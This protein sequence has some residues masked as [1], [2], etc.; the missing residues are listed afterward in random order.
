[1]KKALKGFSGGSNDIKYLTVSYYKGHA[2]R[3][4]NKV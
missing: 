3:G 1:M 2:V 4:K